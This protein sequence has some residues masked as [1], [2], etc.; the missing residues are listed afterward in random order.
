M[1]PMKQDTHNVQQVQ[2][3][4]DKEVQLLKDS[5]VGKERK[6]EA[7]K[8][9][10][11]Y[12]KFMRDIDYKSVNGKKYPEQVC[13]KDDKPM[14]KA[15]VLKLIDSVDIDD[16]GRNNYRENYLLNDGSS[17]GRPLDLSGVSVGKNR[18]EYEDKG[19]KD[20]KHP[21]DKV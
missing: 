17:Y 16:S 14:N 12:E 20:P 15:E 1:E 2:A 7:M 10:K 4:Y 8:T 9:L 21:Y 13:W 5:N 6:R 11:R 3:L 19:W 18:F